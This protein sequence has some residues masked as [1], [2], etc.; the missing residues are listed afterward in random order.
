MNLAEVQRGLSEVVRTGATTIDDDYLRE[1][2]ASDRVALLR[3]IV[4]WWR[5]FGVQRACPLSAG[6]LLRQGRLDDVVV[7]FV[8]DHSI[9]PYIEDLASAFVDALRSD[10]DELVAA[11]AS[12]EA[13]IIKVKRGDRGRHVVPWPTEPYAV[14]GALLGGGPLPDS[15]GDPAW[16]VVAADL[17]RRFEVLSA[18]PSS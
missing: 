18:P 1:V 7:R 9:S 3:E 2:A 8:A 10:D 14:L 12:F 15:A 6:L 17:P 16:T 11:V 13:A 4:V 5:S